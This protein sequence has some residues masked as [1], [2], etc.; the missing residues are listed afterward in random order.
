M[1][2]SRLIKNP[3]VVCTDMNDGGVLLDLETT[4]YFS[5]NRTAFRIWN[6]IDDTSTVDEI[7]TRMTAEFMVDHE[8]ALASARRLV[9][10]LEHERLIRVESA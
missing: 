10:A 3:A 8:Q 7:A 1:A 9:A 6:F 5:L 2:E 4:A